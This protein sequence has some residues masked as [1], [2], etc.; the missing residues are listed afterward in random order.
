MTTRHFIQ[1]LATAMLLLVA[2]TSAAWAN[3]SWN[4]TYTDEGGGNYRFKGGTAHDEY[5]SAILN[6]RYF[7][8]FNRFDVDNNQFY[9]RFELRGYHDIDDWLDYD[10]TIDGEMFLVTSDNVS[11][12]IAK[13]QRGADE[14]YEVSLNQSDS[15]WGTV[16]TSAFNSNGKTVTLK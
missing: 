16:K 10:S 11:H 14:G 5:E 2:G 12:T 8:T 4:S 13:W 6:R 1:Q 9:W 3:K 7:R 15:K